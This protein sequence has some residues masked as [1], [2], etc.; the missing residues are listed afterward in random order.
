[1]ACGLSSMMGWHDGHLHELETVGERY[2]I[3]DPE[4]DQG[5]PPRSE[6]RIQF[7]MALGGGSLSVAAQ[8]LERLK[9]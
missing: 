8:R 7:K 4:F 1:M 6:W 3:P 2:G 5:D 9:A